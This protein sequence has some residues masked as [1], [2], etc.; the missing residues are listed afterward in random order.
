MGLRNSI[1]GVHSFQ[2]DRQEGA[3][4]WKVGN[5]CTRRSYRI[6]W[7]VLVDTDVKKTFA[8][9]M[10]SLFRELLECTAE[11]ELQ[12]VKAAVAS[13]AARVCRRKRLGGANNV[14]LWRNQEVKDAIQAKK[15]VAHNDWLQ[16]KAEFSFYAR[17]AEARKS[18][19]LTLKK[20]KTQSCGNFRNKLDKSQVCWQTIRC[21][22]QIQQRD[23]FLRVLILEIFIPP[24]LNFHSCPLG[25]S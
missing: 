19:A 16:N 25:G 12:M 1:K 23:S 7:E 24:L 14:T 20:S 2:P 8:N 13:S 5:Q 3:W 11:V 18:A 6:K 21:S 15:V 17:Y 4:H 22:C 10:L 9:S